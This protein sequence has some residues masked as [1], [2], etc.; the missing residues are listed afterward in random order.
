M[1]ENMVRIKKGNN[2][3]IVL[4]IYSIQIEIIL[5]HV[6]EEMVLHIVFSILCTMSSRLCLLKMQLC[7]NLIEIFFRREYQMYS[8]NTND[9]EKQG[10]GAK[11]VYVKLGKSFIT[12]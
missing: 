11:W 1:Q 9:K 10:G 6:F 2:I 4:Q 7:L 12:Y 8:G 3:L 5:M